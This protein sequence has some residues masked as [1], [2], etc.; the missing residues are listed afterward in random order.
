MKLSLI[1]ICKGELENLQK[2]H[3][4]IKDYVDEWVVV[5]PPGD[6][7]VDFL[8]DKAVVVEKDFTQSIEPDIR[9]KMK[10]FGLEVDEDYRLFNFA[11]A[12]N[13]SMKH[14]TGDYIL[15]FDGD[16]LPV[17]MDNL[18]KYIS[19]H[20]EADVFNA[21]YD[22]YKDE[23]GNSV[24]DHVRERVVRN[25]GMFTWKGG[26]LGLI[27]E[28]LLPTDKVY[29]PL[30]DK[31][32]DEIFRIEHH[33]DHVDESSLR[34]HAALLYEYLKTEGEDPRTTYYLGIEYFNRAMYDL[35]TKVLHEY[36]VKGGW[37]EERYR[38]WIKIAE[39][40]AMM[41]DS[42]SSRNSY[43]SAMKEMPS[44][45]DAYLGLGES[46]HNDGEWIKSNEWI[47]TGLQKKLPATQAVIDKVR[48]TFRPSV[49]VALNYLQMGNPGE[50]YNWFVR[51]A[52]MN[53]KHPWI[54][55]NA[56]LFMDSKELDDYVKSFVKLGQIAQRKYPKLL[57][58]LAELVPDELKDQEILMDFKWRY[59]KPKIWPDN[60]I[61]YFCS[62][63][64]EDWGP[65]SLKTGCGGSEEA[66]IH[67][68]KRWAKMGYDVTVYNNCPE[69][70][71]VDGV[72]WK[73]YENF[74][75]R[76]IFNILISWRNNVFV[77]NKIANKKIIDLHDVVQKD[78]YKEHMLQ[79]VEVFVKSDY[80]R[81]ILSHLPD[82]YFKIIPNGIDPEQFK[83]LP[84]KQKNN[85][86]WTSSYDR[87]LKPLLEMWPE[88]LKE[89]PDATLD[90]AYGFNIL[91]STAH[92]NSKEGHAWKKEMLALMDQ[93]GVTHHGRI[94][95]T[96]VAELYRKADVWAYPTDFPEI[97]CITATKA[98]AAKCVPITTDFA[99]MKERNQGI[100]INGVPS[101]KK[102]REEFLTKLIALL[103]DEQLKERIRQTLDVSEFYW[104]SI[105]SKWD[106]EFKS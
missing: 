77:D 53:P 65:D 1:Q 52:K 105:A 41:G 16:D 90:I 106:K 48:Y 72:H 98:M 18:K 27:H 3:P 93:K 23:E 30:Y 58:K 86:V 91:D 89:V 88:I 13:E 94:N 11:G 80:H 12:R 95:T 104:D 34:N 43:L 59:G 33:T 22:Y 45:P 60:S 6:S 44:Y 92:G 78:F 102:V 17:G 36:I 40:Y 51:A 35:C 71:T 42:V 97:D 70:T 61:V 32:P 37:D 46:Y 7:A 83:D 29:E 19:A 26:K 85:L 9:A 24:S 56:A 28:T 10:T 101:D 21:V 68:T 38:A 81:Q 64:F 62:N 66:V 82:S 14:A 8:K 54:K 69:E 63:A 87:G 100:M 67:L 74:N 79:D 57:S 50:G 55:E 75:P 76:D 2:I 31:I 96:E 84:K 25:N 15:W 99:V 73:R 103:K 49:Y 39:A 5:V 47:M 4:L 20:P